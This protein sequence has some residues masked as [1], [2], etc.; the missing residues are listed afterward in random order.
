VRVISAEQVPPADIADL[1][2][3]L[4]RE[5]LEVD[6]LRSAH[7]GAGVDDALDAAA[8]ALHALRGQDGHHAHR[9]RAGGLQRQPD[10]PRSA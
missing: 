4:A 7:V 5:D 2:D 1:R 8:H 6:G 10:A 3:R 9:P